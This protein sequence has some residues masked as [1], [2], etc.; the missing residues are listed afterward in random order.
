MKNLSLVTLA[1]LLI[2]NVKIFAQKSSDFEI[3]KQIPTTSVKDQGQS[4]T[5]WD[6]ATLSFLETEYLRENK[7]EIDLSEMFVA[8]YAFLAKAKY[9][10]QLHGESNFSQGGQA[11]DVINVIKTKGIVLDEDYTGLIG[12]SKVYNHY[13]LESDLKT[14]LDS[15]IATNKVTPDIMDKTEKI[16][17]ATLGVLPT[18]VNYKS[19]D[20][21]PL[22]FNEKV[23]NLD[24]N[25][26]VEITS[27]SHHDYYTKFDLEIP[28]NW[29]HDLYYN[30]KIEDMITIINNA[31]NN[32][33]SVCWDGDVSER[34]FNHAKSSAE[35]TQDDKDSIKTNGIEKYRETTFQ[36]YQTTDDHLMHLTGMA[37]NKEGETY[38]QIKNSWGGRSN[39][40][41]GFLYMSK[42][43]VELK[44][45]AILV[46][47][48]AIP[49][50]LKKKMS[51]N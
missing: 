4:G 22:E 50:D 47:K 21:T 8:N 28:D 11:H 30:V 42:D 43:F 34:K 38:Y 26:Y 46:N 31:V 13:G 2:L 15:T 18:K 6:F 40:S 20:Y 12:K 45:I 37:Q 51:I 24:M 39:K 23:L 36:N 35:L 16:I 5:C 9:Y 14:F 19:I 27:Y 3:I 29:S 17:S 41:D 32:G 48:N 33:Y 10:L 7:E 49:E 44:T 25:N 1:I